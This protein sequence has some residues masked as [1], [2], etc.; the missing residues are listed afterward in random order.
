MVRRQE[1]FKRLAL[2][3]IKI[4]INRLAKKKDLVA[5]SSEQMPFDGSIKFLLF[6]SVSFRTF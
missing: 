4:S 1:N 3:D 2:T 6:R 5:V